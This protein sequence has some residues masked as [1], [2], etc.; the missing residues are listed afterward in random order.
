MHLPNDVRVW[1]SRWIS[2]LPDGSGIERTGVTPDVRIEHL[3]GKDPALDEAVK[4]LKAKA[5]KR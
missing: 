1:F 3:T 5:G 2:L 4:I